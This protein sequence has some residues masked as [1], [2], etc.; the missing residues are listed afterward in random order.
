MRGKSSCPLLVYL[1]T[2][3]HVDSVYGAEL[4]M[5]RYELSRI[6]KETV[7]A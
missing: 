4:E 2:L 5:D 7:M 6:Y 1:T 3:P